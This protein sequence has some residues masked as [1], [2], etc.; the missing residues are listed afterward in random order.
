M[1]LILAFLLTSVLAGMVFQRLSAWAY[2]VIAGSA[3]ATTVL[4]Y[5]LG[6]FWS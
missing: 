5:S 6:R 2:V 4:F 1:T 3:A